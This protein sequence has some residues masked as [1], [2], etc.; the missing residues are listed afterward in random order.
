MV[1]PHSP[2]LCPVTL[3]QPLGHHPHIALGND[4]GPG[5]PGQRFGF[6]WMPEQVNHSLG[7][8]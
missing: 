6:L 4:I 5:A 8:Y 1:L 7:E 3:H 2:D